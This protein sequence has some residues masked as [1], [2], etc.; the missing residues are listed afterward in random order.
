MMV[1]SVLVAMACLAGVPWAVLAV[2]VFVGVSPPIGVAVIVAIAVWQRLRRRR[3]SEIGRGSESTLL[4]SLAATVSTGAT[5]RQAIAGT[6]SPRITTRTRRLCTLG[7]P[8]GSV[9]ASM[10]DQLPVTGRAFSALMQVSEVAGGSVA[11]ALHILAEQ[12]DDADDHAREAR[13]V[14]AQ[15][16]FSAIVVGVVPPAAAASVF[17]IRGLP[18]SGGAP[19]L[20]PVAGG[21][22]LMLLGASLVFTMARRATA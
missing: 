11:G 9:G 8:M 1:L 2:G 5:V 20:L 12:A 13:V 14:S 21:G 10:S 17:A 15:A 7:A 6:R 3:S 18:E 16:K 19:V 4:R 22:V